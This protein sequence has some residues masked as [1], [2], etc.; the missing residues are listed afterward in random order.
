MEAAPDSWSPAQGSD[1]GPGSLV[2]VFDVSFVLRSDA[3][4]AS[5]SHLLASVSEFQHFT[6]QIRSL[7]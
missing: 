2:R 1:Q 7:P 5:L 6:P 3:V 4:P